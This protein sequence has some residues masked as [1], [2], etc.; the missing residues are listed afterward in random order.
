MIRIG[1]LIVIL[2]IGTVA[3]LSQVKAE[4]GDVP[5]GNAKLVGQIVHTENSKA[6]A[7]VKVVLYALPESGT[8]G[9]RSTTS[10]SNGAFQFL[11][12]SGSESVNYLVGARYADVPYPGEHFTFQEGD[13]E[14]QVNIRI[15][16]ITSNRDNLDQVAMNLRFDW[17]GQEVRVSETYLFKNSE[18]ST[19]YISDWQRNESDPILQTL[20]PDGAYDFSNALGIQPEGIVRSASHIDYY[21]PIY[22]GEQSLTF[23]YRLE[24]QK[25]QLLTKI[26][27]PEGVHQVS[28]LTPTKGPKLT[29]SLIEETSASTIHGTDFNRFIGPRPRNGLLPISFELPPTDVGTENISITEIS[30]V[31]DLDAVALRVRENHVLKVDGDKRIAAPLG[32]ALLNISLPEGA[33]EVRF[34]TTNS[35]ATMEAGAGNLLKLIGPLPPGETTLQLEYKLPVEGDSLTLRKRFNSPTPLLSVFASDDGYLKIDAGRLHRRRPAASLGRNYMHFE[36]FEV[37]RHEE[38]KV[39]LSNVSPRFH[40]PRPAFLVGIGVATMGVI[41]GIT[42]PLLSKSRRVSGEGPKESPQE[43]ELIALQWALSDLDHDLETGKIDENDFYNLKRS[44]HDHISTIS[45]QPSAQYNDEFE[46]P[47]CT[48]CNAIVRANDKFCA[49]CGIQLASGISE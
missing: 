23:S 43:N 30:M 9:L 48:D 24:T 10:D 42:G 13:L 28:L 20:L 25:N 49:A 31:L 2:L 6:V 22:P 44:L 45:S 1:A 36:A 34:A 32:D 3:M 8:P 38:V 18:D 21:G 14:H 47:R 41:F 29:S 27:V 17:L 4:I 5:T 19:I 35:G 26:Y 16:E 11:N 33:R 39:E 37:E 12:I 40:L 15:Y 46:P 7:N